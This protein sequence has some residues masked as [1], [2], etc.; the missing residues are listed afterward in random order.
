[1]VRFYPIAPTFG[2]RKRWQG[3]LSRMGESFA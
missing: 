3:S 1:M 2:A